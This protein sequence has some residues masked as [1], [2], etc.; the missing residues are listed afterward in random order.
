MGGSIMKNF[1][2][3]LFCKKNAVAM[4]IPAIAESVILLL[5]SLIQRG[6][7]GV[8]LPIILLLLISLN[9]IRQID[10][11]KKFQCL[12]AFLM[13][14]LNSARIICSLKNFSNIVGIIVMLPIAA[15]CVYTIIPT[16]K[17]WY[18]YYKQLKKNKGGMNE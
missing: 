15:G 11:P 13:F 18:G 6:D 10:E 8:D 4:I 9:N 3:K 7:P 17:M 2:D 1:T 5:V 14:Y 16:V 12:P